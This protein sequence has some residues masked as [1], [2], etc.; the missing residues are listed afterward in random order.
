ME[1][2][3]FYIIKYDGQIFEREFTP[4]TFSLAVN[5][6]RNGGILVLSDI[7]V[8]LGAGKISEIIDG[9]AYK[10]Y[11][12]T[13]VKLKMYPLDGGWYDGRDGSFIKYEEWKQKLVDENKQKRIVARQEL[14]SSIPESERK[15]V[16]E[17]LYPAFLERRKQLSEKLNLKKY[18]T[19]Q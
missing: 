12:Q 19:D 18:A 6:W 3:F 4:E 16:E 9:K 8:A 5:E 14:I 10:A 15:N 7:G 1:K 11:L 2:Q 13:V 17:N